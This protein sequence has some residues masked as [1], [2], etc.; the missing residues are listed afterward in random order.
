[1]T[2]LQLAQRLRQE[3]GVSGVGPT[4]VTGQTG[5]MKRLVDW[6]ASAWTEIQEL[7][8]DWKFLRLTASWAAVDGQLEYTTAQCGVTA[9]TF[10]SWIRD[11]FRTYVTATGTSSEMFLFWM[12]YTVWRNTW[13]FGANRSVKSR[14]AQ[15]TITPD[16]SIGLGPAAASGYTMSGDYYRSSVTLAADSDVPALPTKHSPM[17]IVYLA[18]M[19]YGAHESAP[20]VYATGEKEYKRLL[21]RLE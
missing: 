17:I 4:A 19:K 16:D 18:M 11:S 7:H 21:A 3:C 1:M 10:G 8:P 12:P 6:I 5:E 20:E 9:G 13:K 15:F 14:P 2:F